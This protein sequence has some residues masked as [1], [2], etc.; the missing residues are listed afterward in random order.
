VLQNVGKP[1]NVV[2]VR[3]RE[4]KVC[5]IG[6]I[7]SEDPKIVVEYEPISSGIEEDFSFAKGDERRE[8]PSVAKG[9]L[10]YVIVEDKEAHG[11]RD[12]AFGALII[13]AAGIPRSPR[14]EISFPKFRSKVGSP[15]GTKVR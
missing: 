5:E 10:S 15:A 8:A 13:T 3:V 11:L 4:E 1:A 14:V 9:R 2:T 6:E 12:G 7:N